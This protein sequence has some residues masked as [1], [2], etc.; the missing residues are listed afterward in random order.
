[1]EKY[2]CFHPLKFWI[3]ETLLTA[4]SDKFPKLCIP[5]MDYSS[6]VDIT[7]PDVWLYLK[8]ATTFWN[9]NFVRLVLLISIHLYRIKTTK[10]FQKNHWVYFAL[11]WV[12]LQVFNESKY[13]NHLLLFTNCK[14]L[15]PFT[16]SSKY[17]TIQGLCYSKR[18][19][20]R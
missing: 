6:C 18:D 9:E 17:I 11:N 10:R 19:N 1:M 7:A 8:N 3:W 15:Y 4:T 5:V 12:W 14:K 16:L 2:I 13:V 20:W